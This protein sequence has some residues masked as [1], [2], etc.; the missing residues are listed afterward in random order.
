MTTNNSMST[1]IS[2]D[3]SKVFCRM[4]NEQHGADIM[5]MALDQLTWADRG[6]TV[7]TATMTKIT[8]Y[9]IYVSY[10]VCKGTECQMR[11][12]TIP[13]VPPLTSD[14]DVE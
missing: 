7:S 9:D 12:A 14:K 11:N 10:A 8:L 6:R 4:M 3:A 2:P 5:A 13:F 1:P